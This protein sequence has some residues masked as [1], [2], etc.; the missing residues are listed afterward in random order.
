MS[1]HTKVQGESLF[2]KRVGRGAIP[3]SI[4]DALRSTHLLMAVATT[5]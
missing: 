4:E 5:Q 3:G 1:A 2:K